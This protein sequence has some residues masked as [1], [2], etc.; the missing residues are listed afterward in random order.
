MSTPSMLPWQ[1]LQALLAIYQRVRV[2]NGYFTDLG[3]NASLES[4]QQNEESLPDLVI[5]G[6]P[7][8]AGDQGQNF[9]SWTLEVVLQARIPAS[10]DNAQYTAWMVHADLLAA[11]PTK[12]EPLP[13]GA[14]SISIASSAIVQYT[15]GPPFI[16]VQ[17]RLLIGLVFT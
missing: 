3:Q 12:A 6:T 7:Q 1:T 11:T 17:V 5:I 13:K 8:N 14:T 2:S 16:V 15:P 10:R 4:P 9:R